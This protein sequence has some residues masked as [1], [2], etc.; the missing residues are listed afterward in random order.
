[1][2]DIPPKPDYG[3]TPKKKWNGLIIWGAILIA[4]A[5]AMFVAVAFMTGVGAAMWGP[6]PQSAGPIMFVV[7]MASVPTG[8]LGTV[9]LFAGIILRLRAR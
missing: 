4:L 6:L 9:L 3:T 2:A 7:L 1:M 8:V 5:I